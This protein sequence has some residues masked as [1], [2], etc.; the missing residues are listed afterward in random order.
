M[1]KFGGTGPKRSKPSKH[2]IS[3]EFPS[4]Q[5]SV[6]MVCTFEPS[7]GGTSKLKTFWTEMQVMPQF[8]YRLTLRS[9]F[10][11]CP[12][13]LTYLSTQTLCTRLHYDFSYKVL[14]YVTI[15]S[16]LNDMK[17]MT[18]KGRHMFRS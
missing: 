16:E 2:G 3:G 4:D 5:S 14:K 17:R 9:L 7:P 8:Y 10:H 11:Q 15:I 18:D 13:S 6:S 1:L 12:V